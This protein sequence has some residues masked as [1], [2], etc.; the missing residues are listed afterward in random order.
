MAAHHQLA[1][2][3]ARTAAAAQQARHHVVAGIRSWGI[4]L[5]EEALDGIELAAG[6]LITNAVRHTASGLVTV[7]VCWEGPVLVVEVHDA[8]KVL[9]RPEPLSGSSESGRG[10]YLVSVLA[11]R[12]GADLTATGKRCW[13]EFDLPS[14]AGDLRADRGSSRDQQL[15]SGRAAEVA[16]R[17]ATRVRTSAAGSSS[18]TRTRAKRRTAAPA[19][20]RSRVVQLLD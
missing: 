17:A 13:A 3:V 6:E 10:L 14:S 11:D 7:S 20:D 12:H 4:R 8:T 15:L 2:T 9:P 5:D 16:D 19:A 1:F 18:N